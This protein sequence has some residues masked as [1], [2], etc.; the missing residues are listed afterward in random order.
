MSGAMND[1]TR[2]LL[3]WVAAR[4]R[5]YGEAMDAWRSTCPR[6]SVWEDALIGGLIKV[7]DSGDTI[8]QSKVALTPL[9]RTLLQGEGLQGEGLD[10]IRATPA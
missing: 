6:L 2:E 8:D 7:V 9:G 5:T 10:G 4:P 3:A 1:S